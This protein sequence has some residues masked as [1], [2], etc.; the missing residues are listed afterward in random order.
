MGY[1][2]GI[3]VGTTFT[4][5]AI[6]RDDRVEM[7]GLGNRALQ[8]P[9]VVFVKDDGG[10][11]VGDAAE[12]RG[13]AEPAGVVREFKRR[14]GDPVPILVRGR[15]YSPQALIARLLAWVVAV[16][17]ERQGQAPEKIV[18]SH[19]ANWG[20]FKLDLLRQAFQLA[21]LT[22]VSTCT[23]PEAAAI[24]YAN[25]QRVRPGEC[26]AVYDLG[27]GTFDATV[28]RNDAGRFTLLGTPEG[29]EH[30]GGIDFDEAIFSRV[31][32]GA[33]G[34][35]QTLN[36]DDPD[37]VFA[38]GRL[39]R[40]CVL[41]KETLSSD[42]D[43][44]IAVVLPGGYETVRITRSELE[45]MLRPTIEETVGA[46]RRV[47]RSAGVTP[48]DLSAIVLVGGSSRIP[49]VSEVLSG[50]FGCPLAID[51]HPKHD[52]AMGAALFHSPAAAGA[53]VPAVTDQPPAFLAVPD[54]QPAAG[55]EQVPLTQ[56]VPL[57]AGGGLSASPDAAT[58]W[59]TPVA[60]TV[61]SSP[62]PPAAPPGSATP[63]PPQEQRVGRRPPRPPSRF[64][65]WTTGRCRT[66]WQRT[67]WPSPTSTPTASRAC[68]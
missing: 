49:L 6:R 34:R 32:G 4:A 28:L 33:G 36:F 59:T 26:I 7:L 68:G 67:S 11:L 48:A 15:A 35:L 50:A 16:A 65:C 42:T 24:T 9:S 55:G 29:I 51:T 56:S 40:D 23:E 30:L 17:T 10:F 47:L 22:D 41:A 64:R 45:D 54:A 12:T 60:A 44:S 61:S 18:V 57:P 21:D 14:L 20:P 2:L 38:L 46:T 37:V 62:V 31:L 66:R 19:P 52:V 39:R 25:R 58:G 5:A 1:H 13:V 27:G 53:A 8:I 63:R 3:D 43:T